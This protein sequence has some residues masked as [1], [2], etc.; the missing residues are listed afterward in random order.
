VS[1]R[2]A[3]SRARA[4]AVLG[5]APGSSAEEIRS[6]YRDLVRR[7]HP[8]LYVNDS[9]GRMEAE[10]RTRALNEA[11]GVLSESTTFGRGNETNVIGDSDPSRPQS[12]RL[13]QYELDAIVAS[14]RESRRL[15]VDWRDPINVAATI[16]GVVFVGAT[17][18]TA[19]D[20]RAGIS[21]PVGSAL[22]PVVALSLVGVLIPMIWWGGKLGRW[23][24]VPL[25]IVLAVG[26]PILALV[27]ANR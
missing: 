20:P 13:T 4:L 6:R 8:D 2:F 25:L 10:T 9:I 23:V 12:P 26:I 27:L 19:W 15:R 21:D 18:V 11:Y 14:L 1:P 17:L 3:D 7:W 16:V 5:L 22:A 24:A